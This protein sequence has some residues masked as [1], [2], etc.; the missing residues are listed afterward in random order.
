MNGQE[1]RDRY[2]ELIDNRPGLDALGR[3]ELG[4]IEGRLDA[5]D[6]DPQL[7]ARERQWQEERFELLNSVQELLAKLRSPSV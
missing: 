7:E 6:R 1:V 5:E 4:E 2:H 3:F